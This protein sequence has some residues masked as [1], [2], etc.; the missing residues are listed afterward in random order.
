MIF[1]TLNISMGKILIRR[2]KKIGTDIQNRIDF[3]IWLLVIAINESKSADTI[4]KN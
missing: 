1:D 4:Q 3:S 2:E